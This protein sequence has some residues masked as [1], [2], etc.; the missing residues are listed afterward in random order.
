M[1][2]HELSAAQCEQFLARQHI[3][4]L[5]CARED[6]PYIVPIS[7]TF[8]PDDNCLYSFSTVGQKV[9]WMRSNPK[10]CVEVDEIINQLRW[11]TV[12]IVGRYKEI[13]SS[14]APTRQRAVELLQQRTQWWLPGAGE[15]TGTATHTTAVFFG[16]KI[17]RITGR[18]AGSLT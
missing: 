14:D 3:G 5:A 15:T 7:F 6:Q 4:R 10:V 16:V 8:A 12:L 1:L 17:E 18:R 11:T 13:E 9:E 2:I